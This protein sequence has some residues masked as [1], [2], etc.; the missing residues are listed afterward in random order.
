M[1]RFL[2]FR[3]PSPLYMHICF[4]PTPPP[5]PLMQLQTV[6]F[7]D[8]LTKMYSVNYYQ[9]KKHRARQGL[10]QLF[11]ACHHEAVPFQKNFKFCTFLPKF[12]NS[13][14]F[15]EKSHTCPYFLEQA[16]QCYKIKKLLYKAIRKCQ[17][18]IPRRVLG[19]SLCFLTIQG[20]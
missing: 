12:L 2:N 15:S 9:S 5:Q 20:R 19:L 10:F 8:N 14:P 16:L 7:K 3:S 1:V 4:Q 6:F 13:L 11:H 18:K 17:I